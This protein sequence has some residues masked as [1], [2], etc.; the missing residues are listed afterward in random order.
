MSRPMSHRNCD[1]WGIGSHRCR[2]RIDDYKSSLKID[3]E[4]EEEVTDNIPR[5]YEFEA[6]TATDGE[7]AVGERFTLR[8]L[9]QP[10][11]R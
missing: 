3:R 7:S 8:Q 2:Y 6:K 1:D 10:G 9:R 5:A 11:K 4:E